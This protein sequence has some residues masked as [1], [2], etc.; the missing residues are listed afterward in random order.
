MK[1]GL[2][3]GFLALVT[4][5]TAVAPSVIFGTAV[6]AACRDNKGKFV[7]CPPQKPEKCRDTKGRYTKC[8]TDG[9]SAH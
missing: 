5:T 1:A 4:A 9:G 8:T 6:A 2:F 3:A 7:R